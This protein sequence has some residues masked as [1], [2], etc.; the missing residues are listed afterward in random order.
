MK[1]TVGDKHSSLLW[2]IINKSKRLYDTGPLTGNHLK[3]GMG[4]IEKVGDLE[5]QNLSIKNNS[6][7][8]RIEKSHIGALKISPFIQILKIS[9]STFK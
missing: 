6:R 8:T 3:A 4:E 7:N 9:I 5:S 2:R 1:V